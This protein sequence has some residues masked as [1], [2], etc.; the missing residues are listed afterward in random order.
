[1]M[2][3]IFFFFLLTCFV[4]CS[5]NTEKK[6]KK[7]MGE[8]YNKEIL[9]PQ[10]TRLVN[11]SQVPSQQNSNHINL[12]SGSYY[13][14]HFFTAD[15]DKCIEQIKIA[16]SFIRSHDQLK[17]KY[18]F[19]ASAPT[20][21]YVTQATKLAGF[22]QPVYFEPE[23]YS[24]KNLNKFPEEDKSY[25]TMLINGKGRLIFF[26]GFFTNTKAQ[27]MLQEIVDNKINY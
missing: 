10:N 4:S 20:D 23:Y 12:D 9:F 17:I 14:I 21:V 6:L 7:L 15:C 24:F 27:D 26:G 5:N 19:I 1:M 13:I 8:W 16:Q 22:T 2:R 11:T 18:I 25:D 3:I